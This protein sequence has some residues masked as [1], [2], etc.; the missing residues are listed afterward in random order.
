[1]IIVDT[2]IWADHL[3]RPDVR[4]IDLLDNQQVLTH[5]HVIGELALGNLRQLGLFVR[6]M[7]R[8]PAAKVASDQAVLQMIQEHKLSGSG[9]GYTDTHLI[10]SILLTD[11]TLLWT[12]DKR[13]NAVAH[14]Y[15][16]A[17]MA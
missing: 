6:Y 16:R 4:L 1:V 14:R 3:G 13:L 17:W 15:G 12:R 11:D 10:A 8:L 7:Q 9:I 2:S 5:P